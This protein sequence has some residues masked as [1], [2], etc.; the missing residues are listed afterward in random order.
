MEEQ[1]DLDEYV[2]NDVGK[3]WLQDNNGRKMGREWIFGQFEPYVLPACQKA[4]ERSKLNP[5]LRGDP[6]RVTRAISKI[7]SS[8]LK[9]VSLL[10][11]LLKNTIS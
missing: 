9:F 3:I 2:L 6:I 5:I 8:I 1:G 10:F 4:L 11:T 7:V